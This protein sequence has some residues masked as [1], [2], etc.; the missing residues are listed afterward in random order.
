L[1]L[2]LASVKASI[3]LGLVHKNC[4]QIQTIP[5]SVLLVGESQTASIY[6]RLLRF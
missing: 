4:G 5:D 2:L 1:P 6:A 3:V